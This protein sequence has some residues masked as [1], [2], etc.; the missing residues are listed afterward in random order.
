MRSVILLILLA[1]TTIASAQTQKIGP[2]ISDELKAA[3]VAG[4]PFSWRDSDGALRTDD[5]NLTVA[6]RTAIQAVFAAHDPTKK[7]VEQTAKLV[8][9]QARQDF[10]D[11][12]A[13]IEEDATLPAKIKQLCVLLK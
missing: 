2:S 12:C 4:L 8:K 3:G 1:F 10:I 5:P 7:S 6:Q 13:A 11:H 9:S